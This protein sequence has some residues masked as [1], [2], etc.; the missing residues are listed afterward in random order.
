MEWVLWH[1]E[2]SLSTAHPPSG[3]PSVLSRGSVRDIRRCSPAVSSPAGS[4]GVTPWYRR[5][6]CRFSTHQ[7]RPTRWAGGRTGWRSNLEC[8]T[9]CGLRSTGGGP[10]PDR[11]GRRSAGRLPGG[12]ARAAPG[13]ARYRSCGYRSS[14]APA[15]PAWPGN[16]R[17]LRAA[18]GVMLDQRPPGPPLPPRPPQ[19]HRPLLIPALRRRRTLPADSGDPRN[20]RHQS[21]SSRAAPPPRRPGRGTLPPHA[22]W[23]PPPRRTRRRRRPTG[24]S[25]APKLRRPY[26][27]NPANATPRS[28]T[29]NAAASHSPAL[30]AA[31]CCRTFSCGVRPVCQ[32]PRTCSCAAAR[33][34]VGAPFSTQAGCGART[35]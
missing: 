17:P 25:P 20:V 3:R 33:G 22:A 16:E 24:A 14:A 4:G 12:G 21:A 15:T 18:D 35:G 2:T 6:R 8:R 7:P 27:R 11:P 30:C 29:A 19:R 28:A 10:G 1:C 26:R 32:T 5:T 13:C 34:A 31:V 9:G 23:Q